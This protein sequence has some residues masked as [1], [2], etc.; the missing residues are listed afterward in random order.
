MKRVVLG[1]DE[2]G[3]GPFAGPLVVGACILPEEC[4]ESLWYD[5]LNDS[6]KLSRNKREELYKDLEEN[7]IFATGWVSAVEINEI[8]LNEALRLATRRAVEEIQKKKVRFTEIIIDGPINFLAGTKLE[9][10]TTTMIRGDFYV[11]EISAASI[12]AKVEHDHYMFKLAE[13]YPEYGFERHVGY[14]TP[15][16]CQAISDYGVIPEHRV[17][18]KKV[19]QLGGVEWKNIKE[20]PL[21]NTTAKGSKAEDLIVDYLES[22]SHEIMARNYRTKFYEID[23]ISRRYDTIYFTEVKYRRTG[24]FGEPEDM[25]SVDKLVRMIRAAKDFMAHSRR[26]SKR[27]Y[28]YELA[29]GTVFGDDY[30]FDCWFTLDDL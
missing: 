27:N 11:K 30:D 28:N 26:V 20:K 17:F 25:I 14:G 10:F 3:R 12:V 9:K 15:Q 13:K 7:A 23:I 2:A 22:E 18:I 6:K 24:D 4:K 21:K 29:I 19:A 16:H 1:I 8:G 5:E